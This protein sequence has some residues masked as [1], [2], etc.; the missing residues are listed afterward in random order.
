MISCSPKRWVGLPK[1]FL[2]HAVFNIKINVGLS[3]DQEKWLESVI[4]GNLS[5]NQQWPPLTVNQSGY[6][7]LNVQ[8]Y[9]AITETGNY[10][11]SQAGEREIVDGE[12]ERERERERE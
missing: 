2:L 10:P 8:Q 4:Y 11:W 3:E 1:H 7:A 9:T 12:R 6:L 5:S